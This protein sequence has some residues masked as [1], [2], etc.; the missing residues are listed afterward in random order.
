MNW[1]KTYE[2]YITESTSISEEVDAFENLINLPKNS[3]V[4]T[5]V[6]F[7]EANKVLTITLL[8]KLNHYDIAGVMSAIKKN[9]SAIKKEYQNVNQIQIGTNI[10][11]I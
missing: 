5:D 2:S 10:I 8:E 1:V 6:N 4:I 11:N 9:K 3:G 7:D